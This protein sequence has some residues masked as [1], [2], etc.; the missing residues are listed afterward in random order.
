MYQYKAKVVKVVDGDTIH[1]LVDLG[2]SIY[3]EII[4]RFAGIN[5]PEKN[6]QEGIVAKDVLTEK[7]LN[8]S[9]VLNCNGKDKYGRWIAT[10]LLND[11]NVNQ[12]LLDNKYAIVYD[13]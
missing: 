7:L 13:K 8:Q 1:A 2:F 10:V 12:W 9:I 4:F 3:S 11:L 6:T 5:A